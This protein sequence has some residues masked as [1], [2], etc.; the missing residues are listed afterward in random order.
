MMRDW[1]KAHAPHCLL[2]LTVLACLLRA[3][4]ILDAPRPWGYVWDRYHP[5]IQILY[6]T[7]ELP[8]SRA[9]WQCYHPPVF[10]Y[11]G[12]PFYWLGAQIAGEAATARNPAL[13]IRLVIV[14]S[15]VCTVISVFYCDKLLR[16]YR[17]TDEY[18]LLGVALALSLPCLYI[19]SGGVEAD[20]VLTA[21]L[22]AFLYYI[23]RYFC[24]DSGSGIRSVAVLG[25]LAG[26]AAGTKYNGLLAAAVGGALIAS[27][28]LP[29]RNYRRLL[30]D[31]AVLA[32]ITLAIG[33]WKYADNY[34]KYGT[35]LFANGTALEGFSLQRQMKWGEYQFG[36]FPLISAVSLMSPGSPE[37][38]LTDMPPYRNVWSTLHTLFWSDMSLFSRA[39]RH[40]GPDGMYPTKQ[41]PFWLPASVVF[42]ALLP[43][44]LAIVGAG[45]TLTRRSCWPLLVMSGV[46][47]LVYVQWFVAQSEW[48]LKTKYILFLLPAYLVYMCFG[49]KWVERHA[50]APARRAVWAS[51]A[52]LVALTNVYLLRFAIG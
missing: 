33:G 14:L 8:E 19:G 42:L 11:A 28:H 27:K 16:L 48:A 4:L 49:L 45:V 3:V 31:A 5:G 39:N 25:V 12:L 36:T 9:C 50:P 46:T 51:L 43:T 32:A 10:Y 34:Q 37:G 1:V 35:P 6:E 15:L 24:V 38:I 29:R 21:I 47:W 22:C 40:G 13:P 18:R 52:L 23:T 17:L 20:I 30:R 2:V 26:L 7:G 41:I 44:L